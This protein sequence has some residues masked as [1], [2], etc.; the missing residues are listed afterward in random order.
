MDFKDY[1]QI[2][3]VSKTATQDEIRKTYRKL[4]RQY[5]PDVNPGNK[6]AEDRFKEINEAYEALSDPERRRKYDEVATAWQ[7]GRRPRAA[8]GRPSGAPP[9]QGSYQT[10]TE[11]DLQ[12]LFGDANPFSD[13]F[14]SLFGQPSGQ[15]ARPRRGADLD[16]PVDVTLGEAYNG[17]KRLLQLQQPDG[18]TRRVEANIP[19]GVRD[20][21]RVRMAGLGGTGDPPGDLYLNVRLQPDPQ[22][23][24]EGD[25]LVVRAPVRLT[26]AAL[27]GEVEVTKPDGRRLAVRVPAG[28]QDGRRV[29]LRGQ[30]LPRDVST[31]ADA[32][33]GDLLVELHLQLPEPLTEAQRRLFEQLREAAA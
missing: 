13:F 23:A 32:A 15:P 30:G 22:Y 10:V 25:D 14:S 26:T 20:G 6:E 18:T 7:Q 2:L 29:R 8:A 28:S 33:R 17:G 1:Y 27:G 3:G 5:H 16:Y 24:R 9:P 21:V 11:D 31:G 4:A 12:D 19:A